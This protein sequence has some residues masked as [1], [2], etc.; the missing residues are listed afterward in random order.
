MSPP[1]V[2]VDVDQR[3]DREGDHNAVFVKAC[4]QALDEVVADEGL[5]RKL[6]GLEE[7]VEVNA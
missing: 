5:V 4:V 7:H 6:V 3:S 2:I 1:G